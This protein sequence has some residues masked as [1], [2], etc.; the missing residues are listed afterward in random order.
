MWKN[1]KFE[2]RSRGEVVDD[3]PGVKK[4]S[5]LGRVHTIQPNNIECYHLRPLLH[6]VRGL[7]LFSDLKTVN[8]VLQPTSQ[9][10]AEN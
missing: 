2:G 1:N 4:D 3:W 9:S 6:E 5:A 8:S 10:P 7:T